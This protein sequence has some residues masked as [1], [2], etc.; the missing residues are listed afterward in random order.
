MAKIKSFVRDKY[1]HRRAAN[2][3]GEFIWKIVVTAAVIVGIYYLISS[4]LIQQWWGL[5]FDVVD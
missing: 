3:A 4:G 2:R 1:K 5:M